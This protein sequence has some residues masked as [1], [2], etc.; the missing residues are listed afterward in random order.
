MFVVASSLSR[1]QRAS[2]TTR[3]LASPERPRLRWGCCQSCLG[4]FVVAVRSPVQN[5]ATN[6]GSPSCA[7]SNAVTDNQQRPVPLG[8]MPFDAQEPTIPTRRRGCLLLDGRLATDRASLDRRSAE[9]IDRLRQN[10]LRTVFVMSMR[11][12]PRSGTVERFRPQAS[13][14][15]LRSQRRV[16]RILSRPR[17]GLGST[18]NLESVL[19]PTTLAALGR[20]FP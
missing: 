4:M 15:E 10:V 5:L 20:G 1:S 7:T 8:L 17:I 11:P 14:R 18:N 6:S 9:L 12:D 16:L 19:G 2:L 3:G 13:L